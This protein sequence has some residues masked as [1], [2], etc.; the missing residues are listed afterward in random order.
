[1]ETKKLDKTKVKI[2]LVYEACMDVEGNYRL[3][4]LIRSKL[5]SFRCTEEVY[6]YIQDG[7]YGHY[8]S[9]AEMFYMP[10]FDETGTVIQL[11][12]ADHFQNE[13]ACMVDTSF[14]LST[15]AMMRYPITEKTPTVG[16]FFTLE[17]S[18]IRMAEDFNERKGELVYLEYEGAIPEP[19]SNMMFK[20]ADDFDIYTWDWSQALA[21]F[22]T[23]CSAEYARENQY[24]TH[25]SVGKPEDLG[26]SYWIW[27]GSLRGD[28]SV[29][30]TVCC[31]LNKAPGWQY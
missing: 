11:M 1:M 13:K 16:E 12:Q 9:V 28:D 29:I 7:L 3:D 22:T 6:S 4:M 19:R 23:N 20:M 21:P 24:V 30:D 2:G 31:F 15:Y 18:V 5:Q 10:V 27:F 17:G 8:P 26:K 25:F 14:G